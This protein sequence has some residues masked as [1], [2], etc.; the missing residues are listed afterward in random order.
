MRN[1]SDIIIHDTIMPANFPP[2]C[3]FIEVPIRIVYDMPKNIRERHNTSFMSINDAQNL[4]YWS[5]MMGFFTG[6]LKEIYETVLPNYTKNDAQSI[7]DQFAKSYINE[8]R[9]DNSYKELDV[10]IPIQAKGIE[11]RK[12]LIDTLDYL[13]IIA[14]SEEMDELLVD[15]YW[16]KEIDIQLSESDLSK[17]EKNQWGLENTLKFIDEI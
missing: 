5:E 7:L 10:N 1:L 6:T 3:E 16:N 4:H 8:I 14:N 15:K 2:K 12:I 11:L 17:T 9:K 13:E